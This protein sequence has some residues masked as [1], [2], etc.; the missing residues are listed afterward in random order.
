MKES[1]N[2]EGRL[3]YTWREKPVQLNGFIC[4]SQQTGFLQ[5]LLKGVWHHGAFHQGPQPGLCFRLL[6]KNRANILLPPSR[7]FSEGGT[8]YPLY[9]KGEEGSHNASRKSGVPS[10][11]KFYYCYFFKP[12][13]FS[14]SLLEQWSLRVSS[15]LHLLTFKLRALQH[16]HYVLGI[17]TERVAGRTFHSHSTPVTSTEMVCMEKYL[18]GSIWCI[19]RSSF[20]AI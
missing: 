20:K 12:G 9:L 11:H 18:S 7:M 1:T 14:T 17:L 5:N 2:L 10:F 19:F 15:A 8:R 16:S 4:T 6:Q 13:S 3:R